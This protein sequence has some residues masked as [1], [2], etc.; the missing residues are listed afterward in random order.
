MDF[1]SDFQV[2]PVETTS[3]VLSEEALSDKAFYTAATSSPNPIED[4][5]TVYAELSQQGESDMYNNAVSRWKTEQDAST[6]NTVAR[7][8]EDP[9]IDAVTKKDILAQYAMSGY[10]SS[11]LKDK[12][13]EIIASTVHT[14][15][16]SHA[17]TQDAIV[18]NLPDILKNISVDE[19]REN[20][21]KGKQ[22]LEDTFRGNSNFFSK[23]VRDKEIATSI[24]IGNVFKGMTAGVAGAFYSLWKQDVL[25]GQALA[26]QLT[27]DWASLP[28]NEAQVNFVKALN[29]KLAVLGIPSEYVAEQT[30][31]YSGKPSGSVVAGIVGDPLNLLSVG[32]GVKLIETL[33]GAKGLLKVRAGSPIDIAGKTNPKIAADIAK[34][35]LEDPSETTAKAVGTSKAEIVSEFVLPKALPDDVG[36]RYPSLHNDLTSLDTQLEE[37][38]KSNKFDANV[39]NVTERRK[40]LDTIYEI[41]NEER[42]PKYM[43]SQSYIAPL[44]DTFSGR[45]VFGKDEHSFYATSDDVIHAHESIQDS[46]NRMYDELDQAASIKIKDQTTGKLYS[47]EEFKKTPKTDVGQFSVE[48]EWNKVYDETLLHIFGKDAVRTKFLGMD[49]SRLFRTKM[50]TWLSSIGRFPEWVE[51]GALMSSERGA[52]QAKF[53][54]DLIK[55]KIANTKHP[56]EFSVLVN[57]ADMKNKEFYYPEEIQSMFPHL[58]TK[59]VDDLFEQHTYWRRINHY[60]HEISNYNHLVQLNREGFGRG[61]YSESR[62]YD[63]VIGPVNPDFKFKNTEYIPEKVWD[64]ETKSAVNFLWDT[65]RKDGIFHKDGRQVVLPRSFY[66][67]PI[68][69]NIFEYVLVSPKSVVDKLPYEVLPRRL[70]HSPINTKGTMFVKLTPEKLVINGIDVKDPAKLRNYYKIVGS[71][72]NGL[73]AKRLADKIGKANPGYFAEVVPAREVQFGRAVDDMRSQG[74]VLHTAMQRGEGLSSI[75]GPAPI[76][77]RLVSM[78]NSANSLGKINALRPWE[79][80]FIDAYVKSYKRFLTEPRDKEF[81]NSAADYFPQTLSDIHPLERMTAEEAKHFE[82]AKRLYEYYTKLKVFETMGDVAWEKG[83]SF[84]S[85]LL[86]KFKIPAGLVRELGAKGNLLVSM[87]KQLASTLLIYLSPRKQWII[88]PSQLVEIYSIFPQTALQRL[89]DTS[90]ILL[91]LGAD[92]PVL[93]GKGKLFHWLAKKMS[94]GMDSA[95]FEATLKAIRESGLIQSVDQNILVHGMYKDITRGFVETDFEKA[96]RNTVAIPKGALHLARAVGFD[97]AELTN[98]VGLWMILRDVWKNNHPG[99]NW[100]TPETKALLAR[101][102]LKISGGMNRAGALPY[103]QGALSILFQFAAITQKMTMNLLIDN[104]TMLSGPQRARLAVARMF[105]WGAKYGTLGGAAAY[106]FV[107]RSENPEVHKVGDVLKRGIAD[108]ATNM[109]LEAFYGEP[110][111]VTISPNVS[112]Y[113]ESTTGLAYVDFY[114]EVV[115]LFDER[116]ATPRFPAFGTMGTILETAQQIKTMWDVTPD[117]DIETFKQSIFKAAKV[118]SSM[119]N[120]AKAEIMRSTRSKFTKYGNNL[121]IDFT[122]SEAFAQELGFGTWKELDYYKANEILQ[123]RSERITKMAEQQHKWLEANSLETGDKSLTTTIDLLSAF[124]RVLVDNKNWTEADSK[125]VMDKV[126]DMQKKK[127]KDVRTS[128]IMKLYQSQTDKNSAE[129]EAAKNKLRIY[130]DAPTMEMLDVFD[131]KKDL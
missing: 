55:A 82:N 57:E 88:Q 127:Y 122:A 46:F 94:P 91:A 47:L 126:L 36:S 71:A 48:V 118:A 54:V 101:E 59:Q 109:A 131:G 24:V 60:H 49:F 22:I 52:A 80:G 30:L 103:Q 117:P 93:K 129:L 68:T 78:I 112:A 65:D 107:D 35:A 25:E 20:I 4:Y 27:S 32:V 119:S 76:E 21:L 81:I 51:G 15:S 6:K 14:D 42:E 63:S 105:L 58:T 124:N 85:D 102:A 86:E 12:Y 95:D 28:E 73:E 50:G 61:I 77:D 26:N 106:Y 13:V 53:V 11:D 113:G 104:A 70:G 10:V 92:A 98:K 41:L 23:D 75:D 33:K 111:D 72:K 39:Q 99:K 115:K 96:Y 97:A 2:P 114:F 123:S 7:L 100:N 87:P 38:F 120:W 29:D 74:S 62:D 56:K 64:P 66:T 90:G 108:R 125:E 121:G 128:V 116:P 130:E 18:H 67:D 79:N 44:D 9:S 31:R 84:V 1:P 34:G 17:Q 8:I 43:Q 110:A 83:L 5:N 40:D 37:Q 16:T 19:Q 45:A 89:A 69:G 3:P